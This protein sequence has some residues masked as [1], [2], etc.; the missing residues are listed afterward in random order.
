MPGTS[1][2]GGGA[3]LI[4]WIADR[5]SAGERQ[6]GRRVNVLPDDSPPEIS[7][8][9]LYPPNRHLTLEIRLLIDFLADRFG[10]PPYWDLVS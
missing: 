5:K 4:R 3:D 10:D 8:Y 9:A 7:M 2:V 6:E 1:A